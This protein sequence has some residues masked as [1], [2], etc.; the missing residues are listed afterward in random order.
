MHQKPQRGGDAS[1]SPSHQRC[2]I[3]RTI[4]LQTLSDFRSNR[5]ERCPIHLCK[6]V[7]RAGGD[8]RHW[9]CDGP[10]PAAPAHAVDIRWSPPTPLSTWWRSSRQG[11]GSLRHHRAWPVEWRFG[12]WPVDVRHHRHS[13]SEVIYA[14][15][16][17][18][19]RELNGRF[20][21]TF[22]LTGAGC[23]ATSRR[24][25]SP[26]ALN[27]SAEHAGSI[28]QSAAAFDGFTSI[29]GHQPHSRR[30]SIIG[31]IGPSPV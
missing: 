9:R 2:R 1:H 30:K 7:A 4:R 20:S 29:M 3:R 8:Q 5:H 27:S 23:G 31:Q 26:F 28:G 15:R 18:M 14:T 16:S 11:R 19:T 13:G 6:D 12:Q 24:R 22:N 10:E 25:R 21:P 17:F